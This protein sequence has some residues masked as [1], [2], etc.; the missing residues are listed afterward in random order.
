MKAALKL[1]AS[2]SDYLPAESRKTNRIELELEPGTTVMDL[3]DRYR[4]PQQ[5]CKLVLIDGSF[6]PPEEREARALQ[7]GEVLAIWPP[8]AGG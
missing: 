3:I 4:L 5:L 8:I 6:V 2:L 1:Y 7:E